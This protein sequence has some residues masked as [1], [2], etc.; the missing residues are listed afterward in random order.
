VQAVELDN[1]DLIYLTG[2]FRGR[3]CDILNASGWP[4]ASTD[5]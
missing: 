2:I 1:G 3:S 4:T 5:R